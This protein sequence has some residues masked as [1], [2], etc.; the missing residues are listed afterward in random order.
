VVKINA[1]D[2]AIRRF[3]CDVSNFETFVASVA[4]VCDIGGFKPVF[5][6]ID[7]DKDVVQFSSTEELHEAIRLATDGVL[8]VQYTVAAA[9]VQA[10]EPPIA[11]IAAQPQPQSSS[12][13][14]ISKPDNDIETLANQLR[15]LQADI[16]ALDKHHGKPEAKARRQELRR[17]IVVTRRQLQEARAVLKATK[18]IAKSQAQ[19]AKADAK[20]L[21][22]DDKSADDNSLQLS[23][24]RLD[25]IAALF[26]SRGHDVVFIT[27][28]TLR[29][30]DDQHIDRRQYRAQLEMQGELFGCAVRMVVV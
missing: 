24:E 23:A 12:E 1:P 21:K 5:S 18:L 28:D 29:Q 17:A 11:P 15:A 30:L 16:R 14:P 19:Q 20:A 7:V 4:A 27:R 22:R 13:A 10:V 3:N 9:D 6:Y 2:G 8:R 26:A 25:A